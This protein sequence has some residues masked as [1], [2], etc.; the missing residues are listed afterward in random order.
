MK[1]TIVRQDVANNACVH[2]CGMCPACVFAP[3][4]PG[5]SRRLWKMSDEFE[6][7]FLV[8]LILRCRNAKVLESTQTLLSA[9]LGTWFTY[10][11]SQSPASPVDYSCGRPDPNL[12][13]TPPG[14]DLNHIWTW[15]HSSPDWMKRR[16]LCR[17]FSLCDVELLLMLSNLTSVL[18]NR[19]KRGFMQFGGKI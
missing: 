1:S 8:A 4:A 10:A 9:T 15:F 6:R 11:R 7:R 5:S 18:L 2:M 16:Y 3:T 19:L 12:D 14:I 17:I 13:E